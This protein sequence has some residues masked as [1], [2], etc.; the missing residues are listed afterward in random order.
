MMLSWH[1]ESQ[2]S[3][4]EA[5]VIAGNENHRWAV[6]DTD[7]SDLH[8][9]ASGCACGPFSIPISHR[10]SVNLSLLY[11]GSAAKSSIRASELV[12]A[13]TALRA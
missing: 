2:T 13:R 4:K 8:Q 12:V 3:G 9:V 7:P 11:G 5:H 10:P 6:A 1:S